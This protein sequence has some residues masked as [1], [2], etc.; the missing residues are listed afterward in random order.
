[1]QT[2]ATTAAVRATPACSTRNGHA[3]GRHQSGAGGEMT[4]C[5]TKHR[6]RVNG[7]IPAV[8]SSLAHGQT[9]VRPSTA[10]TARC[11]GRWG[12]ARC[13]A[14]ATWHIQPAIAALRAGRSQLPR[15]A[16]ALSAPE[17]PAQQ[18]CAERHINHHSANMSCACQRAPRHTGMGARWR[19]KA[20]I[21]DPENHASWSREPAAF[22]RIVGNVRVSHPCRIGQRLPW[23]RSEALQ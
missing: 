8:R 5:T 4:P 22:D 12:G 17:L 2:R 7:G 9:Q 6:C 1:M 10:A 15:A 11:A 18:Q 16:E 13:C 14:A 20:D 19:G 23:A 3:S 21:P